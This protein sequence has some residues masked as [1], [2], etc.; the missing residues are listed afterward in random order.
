MQKCNML[1]RVTGF[2]CEHVSVLCL[3][4]LVCH[5]TFTLVDVCCAT[6]SGGECQVM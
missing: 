6:V 3:S 1:H 4:R 2:V 5:D